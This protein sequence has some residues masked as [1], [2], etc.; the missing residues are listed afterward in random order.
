MPTWNQLHEDEQCRRLVLRL[1]LRLFAATPRLIFG[2]ASKYL[3]KNSKSV[4]DCM[5][6]KLAHERIVAERQSLRYQDMGLTWR[7]DYPM[8]SRKAKKQ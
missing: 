3:L 5:A 6:C 2:V 4:T 1:R 7:H 8:L